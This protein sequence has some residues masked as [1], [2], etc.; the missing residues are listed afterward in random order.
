MAWAL[1]LQSFNYHSPSVPVLAFGRQVLHWHSESLKE[2]PCQ[3]TIV[4]K[5]GTNVTQLI[6]LLPLMEN[7]CIKGHNT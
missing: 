1:Q 6:A 2:Q 5:L 3:T 4:M 7:I